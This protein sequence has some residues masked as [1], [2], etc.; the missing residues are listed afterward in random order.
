ME[1]VLILKHC[2]ATVD[3]RPM[4]NNFVMRYVYVVSKFRRALHILLGGIALFLDCLQ[5]LQD[6]F[7]VYVL[8]RVQ[9]D[10]PQHEHEARAQAALPPGDQ[11]AHVS[12]LIHVVDVGLG[13]LHVG[14]SQEA[15]PDRMDGKDQDLGQLK[16]SSL[17]FLVLQKIRDRDL[18]SH[19]Q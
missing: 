17:I 4:K 2:T 8:A 9:P 7:L 13:P 19:F 14:V 3:L 11:A 10:G 15:L 12:H 5:S 16:M 18:G 1:V 6:S